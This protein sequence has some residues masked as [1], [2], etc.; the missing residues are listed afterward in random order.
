MP[1][2]RNRLQQH[3][4]GRAK[5]AFFVRP[6]WWNDVDWTRQRLLNATG[7]AF[8]NVMGYIIQN[9]DLYYTNYFRILNSVSFSVRLVNGDYVGGLALGLRVADNDPYRND[10]SWQYS[11]VPFVD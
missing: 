11:P 5:T 3:G 10:G 8:N 6:G 9:P 4:P 2:W 7:S 1:Q